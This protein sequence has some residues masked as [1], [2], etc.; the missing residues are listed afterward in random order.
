MRDRLCARLEKAIRRLGRVR[1]LD[2]SAGLLAK[3]AREDAEARTALAKYVRRQRRAERRRLRRWLSTDR[4]RRL[5]K[6][7][8]GVLDRRQ[9]GVDR[10]TPGPA[11][12]A[13]RLT[14]ILILAGRGDPLDDPRRAH[15]IRREV[16]FLR[17][18]H[19][20]LQSEYAA[21][22]FEAARRRFVAMQDAAGRWHDLDVLARLAARARRKGRVGIP[23]G[24]FRRRIREEMK[25]PGAAFVRKLVALAAMKNLLLGEQG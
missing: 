12:L 21:A 2:V 6:A 9:E 7:I 4:L 24:A 20:T 15:E 18:A 22:E 8:D 3:G 5:K 13:P 11:D 1:N 17:Y 10:G 19:E 25:E 14:R 23:L 16:R